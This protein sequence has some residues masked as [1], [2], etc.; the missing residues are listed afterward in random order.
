MPSSNSSVTRSAGSRLKGT[1]IEF[2]IARA[3][4]DTF[5]AGTAM[6]AH[7]ASRSLLTASV[8]ALLLYD[9]PCDLRWK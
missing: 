1:A 7:L 5:V 3:K 4:V 9:L 8:A 2:D 6:R